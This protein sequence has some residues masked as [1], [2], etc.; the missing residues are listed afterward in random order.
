M[1]Y[2]VLGFQ[3]SKLIENGLRMDDALILRVIKDMFSS[4]S[5]E[6]KDYGGERFMW[7]N[8]TYLLEQIPIIGSK[9]NLMYKIDDYRKKGL[10]KTNLENKRN[11]KKGN[12]SY[13]SPTIELDKLQDYDLVQNF[14]KGYAEISQGVVQNL[15]NKDTSCLDT[16]IRDIKEEI[17]PPIKKVKLDIE[18]TINEYTVNAELK[19]TIIDFLDMRRKQKDGIT[20]VAITKMLTKLSKIGKT[21]TEKIEILD[22]STMCSYKGIFPLKTGQQTAPKTKRSQDFGSAY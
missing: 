13:V 11:G 1:K 4:A 9:R 12:F 6:F 8:Y 21:D 5:M 22:N 16:S 14:H 15:H 18:K 19:T 7:V 10:L 17:K 20:D 3:Q 2:T